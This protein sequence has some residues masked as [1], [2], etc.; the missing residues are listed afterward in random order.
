MASFLTNVW[1]C[2][3]C[4]WC[5]RHTHEPLIVDSEVWTT[6]VYYHLPEYHG[7][8]FTKKT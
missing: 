2:V 6:T 3:K 4:F 5:K 1:N 7:C 8:K